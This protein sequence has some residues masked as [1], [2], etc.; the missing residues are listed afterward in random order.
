MA[1]R[2]FSFS[3]D[4]LILGMLF[5]MFSEVRCGKFQQKGTVP[6]V[7]VPQKTADRQFA[8]VAVDPACSVRL[9]PLYPEID[10]IVVSP[11]VIYRI[12]TYL[13]GFEKADKRCKGERDVSR[14]REKTIRW[15]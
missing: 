11:D 5:M 12:K 6:S 7:P 15:L 13:E 3:F 1:K 9:I 2:L 4:L 10:E 8:A 14:I